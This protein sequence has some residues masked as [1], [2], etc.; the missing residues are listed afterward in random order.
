MN[1]VLCRCMTFYRVQAAIKRGAKAILD[2][3]QSERTKVTA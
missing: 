2:A 3:R 1:G